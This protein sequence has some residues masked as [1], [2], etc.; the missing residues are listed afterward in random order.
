LK[1]QTSYGQAMLHARGYSAPETKAAFARAREL[2]AGI[3]DPSERFSVLFGLWAN[4]F[5]SGD[6]EP[7]R[8]VTDIMLREVTAQPRSPEACT[9]IRLNGNAHWLAG[10]FAAARADLERALAMF[11]PERDANLVV[12]FAQDIGVAVMS[13]LALAV[14][15]LGEVERAHRFINEALARAKQI[16]HVGTLAYAH[17]H[18]AVFE[19]MRRNPSGAAPHAEALVN[20]SQAHQLPMFAAYGTVYR[21]W[22]RLQSAASEVAPTEMRAAIETCRERGIGLNMPIIATA[23]AEAEMRADA[24]DAALATID[25]AVVDTERHGQ[26]WFAAETHRVRGEILLRRDPSNT[27]P[28]EEAFLTAI[29]IAQQQKARSYELRAALSLAKLYQSTNRTTEAHGMLAPAFEG[30]SSTPEFPEIEEA[31]TLLAALAET[32]EVKNAAASRQRRLQLQTAYANALI[33][34]RGHGARETSAA[35]AK[36]QTLATG[37]GDAAD[38][39]SAYYGQW[40][41]SLNR[42]EPLKMREAAAAFL[43]ETEHRPDSPAAGVA[44]RI[45]GLT[46]L[47]FGDYAAARADIE[48]ALDVLDNER[49][50]ELAFRFG[51]DQVAAAMI[52][53]ALVLWPLGDVG[54]ARQFANQAASQAAKSGNVQTLAYVNYHLCLFEALR[55]DRQ[56]ASPVAKAVLDL[57]RERA[58]PI[59]E[60]AGRLLNGWANWLVGDQETELAEMRQGIER[61][62]ELGQAWHR[63]YFGALLSEAEADAGNLDIAVTELDRHLAEASSTGQHWSDAELH[64]IRGELLIKRD[65]ASTAPAEEAFVAAIAVAREQKARSFELRAALAL[66]KLHQSTGRPAEAHAALAPALEGFLATPEFP[67]IEE[68]QNLLAALAQN[69]E[70]KKEIALRQRRFRLQT[71]YSNALLHGRGMSPPETTAAFAKAREL[72]ASIEDPVERFSAYYGLWVGPFIRGNLAQMREVAE[73]FMRDAERSPALPEAGIAHRLLGT[74]CWYTGDY[75]GARLHLDEALAR[76]DHARDLHLTSSFAY[77]QGA[78]AEFYLGMTLYALGEIERGAYLVEDSLGLALQGGHIPTVA[79]TRH[80]MVVFAAVRRDLD[81]ATS[82]AQALLDLGLT[83]GLPSWHGFAK[84]TLAWAL[85][86]DN[87]QA[88]AE[89]RAALTLQREM[90]FRVEQPLF[91]TL[92]AEAE[93]AAGERDAALAT[94]VEQLVAIE[95]TGE[96]WFAAE[97]HRARGEILLDR[98]PGNKAPAEEAFHTAIAIAREQ[99]AKSFEL[100]AALSLAKLYQSGSRPLEAHAI[101]ASALE[102]FSPTPE[103]PEIAEA[104]AL[105]AALAS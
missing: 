80:Y 74:T 66:A 45:A 13:Y 82:H 51:Q 42:A 50:R 44:Y 17:S 43:H 32:D 9:A 19:M 63:P 91:G 6:L 93:A 77:D 95:Q 73:A 8:E 4:G 100:R 14:W 88:L 16:G 87:P 41:G 37:L 79:L 98:D 84:F 2:T 46:H 76:Y 22:V 40:V 56:R 103:F 99:K 83:H 86:R 62:R 38:R 30:F 72:A 21:A 97:V 1:L 59:W 67:E 28:A 92:L 15:P 96:R 25:S 81:R 33:H 48:K 31:Q 104:R 71:A 3:E 49:D 20:I 7:T 61:W 23:L 34:A 90:D 75:A 36:A 85:R 29:A 58:M 68:A 26:R 89:M 12:R 101:L 18:F 47:Y 57:A 54:R 39:F 27:E 5:V 70:V 65:A 11:D 105:L 10:N 24:I 94:V 64:R 35:F 69:D 60:S 52:Y 55:G 78:V 102:G 53:L